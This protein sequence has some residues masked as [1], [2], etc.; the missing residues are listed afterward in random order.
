MVKINHYFDR[1]VFSLHCEH[2]TTLYSHCT[3]LLN[4]SWAMFFMFAGCDDWSVL[5]PSIAASWT[6]FWTDLHSLMET[7]QTRERE[8]CFFTKFKCFEFDEKNKV[9]TLS[10]MS[11]GRASLAVRTKYEGG[12]ISSA[13]EHGPLIRCPL[14]TAQCPVTL[15][16]V[17]ALVAWL[18]KR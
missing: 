13:E 6:L 16:T 18:I 12:P 9:S 8:S 11:T 15:I 17:I 1:Q 2:W 3:A 4:S 14:G 5:K 7:W 10:D